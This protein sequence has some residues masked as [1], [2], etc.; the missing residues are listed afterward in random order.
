MPDASVAEYCNVVCE[1]SA[2]KHTEVI[3]MY[4]VTIE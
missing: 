2:S 3:S 4:S 1:E